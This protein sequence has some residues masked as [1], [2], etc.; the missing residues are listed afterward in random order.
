MV[1]N[2]GAARAWVRM[3]V[4]IVLAWH[5]VPSAFSI[6]I[7]RFVAIRRGGP[8]WSHSLTARHAVKF[9]KKS[10]AVYAPVDIEE[11]YTAT[12]GG[13]GGAPVGLERDLITRY[14]GDGD[15]HGKG[16]HAAAFQNLKDSM[17]KGEPFVGEDDGSGWIWAVAGLNVNTGLTLELRKS[18]PLG[19][20]ALMVARQGNVE[21]MFSTLNWKLVRRRMNELLG[22]R[23]SDGQTVPG[24]PPP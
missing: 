9:V 7:N 22:K 3:V 2:M 16:D 4:V 11:F 19:M 21:E 5:A 10:Q 6:C 13:E 15:F 12:I 18:T 24:Y 20:R 14:F 8:G 23:D 17:Q 1:A